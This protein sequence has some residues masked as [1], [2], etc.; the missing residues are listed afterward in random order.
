MKVLELKIDDSI[1]ENLKGILELM[2]KNKIKIMELYDDSHIP[3]VSDKEQKDIETRLKNK[4]CHVSC[5]S[6]TVKL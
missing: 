5:R 2:P 3:Y 1:F 4:S 6:K